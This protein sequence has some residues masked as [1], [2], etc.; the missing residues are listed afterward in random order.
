MRLSLKKMSLKKL[1]SLIEERGP[2]FYPEVIAALSGDPRGGAQRLVR[3]CQ[4]QLEA[5]QREQER[6]RRLYSYERQVWAMGYRLVAGLD[7]AGRGPLA[8]PV[9]AAAVILPGEV[10][11]PGLDEA[12]RLPPKRREELYER[13]RQ[14]AVGIGIGMV[15]PD[16][17][18]ESS[19]LLATYK[20]MA[21]AVQ[22]LPVKPDYLLID[23]LHLPGVSQPQAPVVGGEAASASIAA[24]AVVA[25]VTRD[26]YM[27]EMDKLYPQYGFAHH[28]GYGT[29]AHRAALAKYGPC[30]IHR[31][32]NSHRGA[33]VLLP[34]APLAED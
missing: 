13:I 5:C 9:V 1:Q 19:V 27:I 28:K 20:A 2:E 12:K 7:E 15:D 3:Y 31:K 8:G 29:A 17:I 25:K 32:F 18:D 11:L 24:A 10:S 21:K 6:L 26:R 4:A 30:P 16:G 33:P 14:V 34:G 22:N 23:S